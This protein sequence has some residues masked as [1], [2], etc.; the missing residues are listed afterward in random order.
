MWRYEDFSVKQANQYEQRPP[1]EKQKTKNTTKTQQKTQLKHTTKNKQKTTLTTKPK[2]RLTDFSTV[3]S[4]RA[5]LRNNDEPNENYIRPGHTDTECWNCTDSRN[6]AGNT[7]VA[8]SC[9]QPDTSPA[10]SHIPSH[11]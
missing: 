5:A 3:T 2:Y 9:S 10:R 1:G 11:R 6:T 7:A 8:S 4:R